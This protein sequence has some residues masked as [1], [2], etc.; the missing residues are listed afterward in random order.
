M[1]RC[2]FDAFIDD[3]IVFIHLCPA[4]MVFDDRNKEAHAVQ[5]RLTG[6]CKI[7]Q[8]KIDLVFRKRHV[9]RHEM[10]AQILHLVIRR[11]RQKDHGVFLRLS[12]FLDRIPVC[13]HAHARRRIIDRFYSIVFIGK[14]RR[15]KSKRAA[16]AHKYGIRTVFF[17][18]IEIY[19]LKT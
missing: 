4:V 15:I 16:G 10:H 8:Q 7:L 19:D 2:P 5:N 11:H 9:I 1:A 12:D 3:E 14:Q 18:F 6:L 17:F 13:Q